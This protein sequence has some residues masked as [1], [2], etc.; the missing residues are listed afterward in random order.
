MRCPSGKI[1]L[2]GIIPR[3]AATVGQIS[4]NHVLLAG[5]PIFV[6]TASAVIGSAGVTCYIPELLH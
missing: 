4:A 1:A 2:G 6:S 5:I 3:Q